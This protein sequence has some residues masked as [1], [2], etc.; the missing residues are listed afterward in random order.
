MQLPRSLKTKAPAGYSMDMACF[1]SA[2]FE[3]AALRLDPVCLEIPSPA[4]SADN[5]MESAVAQLQG[6]K[7]ASWLH[8]KPVTGGEVEAGPL[9]TS[10]PSFNTSTPHLSKLLHNSTNGR[11]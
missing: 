4:L 1:S 7:G 3:T 5:F 6:S 2:L 10:T 11:S 8:L 9:L